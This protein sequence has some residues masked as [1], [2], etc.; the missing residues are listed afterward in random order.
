MTVGAQDAEIG[1]LFTAAGPFVTFYLGLSGE[2]DDVVPERALR[3]RGLRDQLATAGAD[4]A[5]LGAVDE[6]VARLGPDNAALA[7]FAADGRVAWERRLRGQLDDRAVWGPLPCV[8]PLLACWQ[9]TVPCVVVLTDRTGADLRVNIDGPRFAGEV[10]G[11]DDE[12]ERNAP[13][14]WSQRR[15]QHRAEDS[16]AHNAAQVAKAVTA[17]VEQVDAALVVLAGDVRAVQLLREHLPPRVVPL[18]R[19]LEHGG[20]HPSRGDRLHDRQ[21]RELVETE[22]RAR[23]TGLLTRFAEDRAHGRAAD[24]AT[25]ALDALARSQARTLLVVDDP[26]DERVAWFGPDPADI[27]AE[28]GML[29][30]RVG[31]PTAGRLADVAVRAAWGTGAAVRVLPAGFAD[32]PSEG[33][34]ALLRYPRAN[35][36]R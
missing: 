27:A 24:G 33:L 21:V 17:L 18:V 14:G 28:A 23:T 25:A 12:I 6:T 9:R 3:W 11:S 16:W 32:G 19:Q 30:G 22:A 29:A 15:Y 34:G 13:G 4:G 2:L 1:Q 26:G 8:L 5:T 31:R 20:R 35:G 36:P 7:V 10:T